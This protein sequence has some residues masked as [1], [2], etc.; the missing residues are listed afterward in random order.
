MKRMPKPNDILEYKRVMEE[1]T[2][3]SSGVAAR[4]A[5]S[6]NLWNARTHHHLPSCHLDHISNQGVKIERFGL[7]GK[8]SNRTCLISSDAVI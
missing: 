3:A 8:N 7:T 2:V 6:C 5:P 4:L 1:G